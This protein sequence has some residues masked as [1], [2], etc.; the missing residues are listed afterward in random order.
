MTVEA[1]PVG[2]KCSLACSYCYENPMR[3]AGNFSPGYDLDAMIRGLEAEGG[4][5][6]L[7]G[8]E[9]L[10]MPVRDLERIFEYGYRKYGGNGIQTNGER[11]TAEHIALFVTYQ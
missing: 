10:L 3:D 8:G 2:V 7:F 4:P 6:S 11:I 1:N 5:F 9:P